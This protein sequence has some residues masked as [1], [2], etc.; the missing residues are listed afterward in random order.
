MAPRKR[1]AAG[2]RSSATRRAYTE[3]STDSEASLNRADDTR[4]RSAARKTAP[5]RPAA[6]QT[7]PK[8]AVAKKTSAAKTAPA[9]K[10]AAPRVA[11]VKQSAGVKSTAAKTTKPTAKK[12]PTVGA[13]AAKTANPR[14]RR[15]TPE[16]ARAPRVRAS[17]PQSHTNGNGHIGAVPPGK[18]AQDYNEAKRVLG[19]LW[20]DITKQTYSAFNN[21]AG[22]VEKNFH[23]ARQNI[24]EMDVRYALEKTSAKLKAVSKSSQASVQQMLRQARLLYAMLRDAVAGRFK[25]PWV[26]VS[27]ATAALLYFISPI[28]LLPDFI[29]GV[30][31]IDD[32]LV[33]AM[34]I[35]LARMDLKR[36]LVENSLDAADYGLGRK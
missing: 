12:T 25:V 9:A 26:T 28:D 21:I 13:T 14:P 2:A 24:N 35:S 7:A 22:R 10:K 16:S 8:K 31:L 5:A 34:A 30:G 17:S 11:A 20:E 1:P 36:Y 4:G 23:Q 29:P 32:A 6:K 19:A 27:A 18:T 33:I 3:D 15:T